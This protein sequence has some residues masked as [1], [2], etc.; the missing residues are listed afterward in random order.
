MGTTYMNFSTGVF[1][2]DDDAPLTQEQV[3]SVWHHL[4][5]T[6][7]GWVE[8][9][10]LFVQQRDDGFAFD[11]GPVEPGVKGVS[12]DVRLGKAKKSARAHS[13]RKK[14]PARAHATKKSPAQLDR[15]IAEVVPGWAR[16]LDLT[17]S[18]EL[19]KRLHVSQAELEAKQR[20]IESDRRAALPSLS[21]T[22][23]GGGIFV[24]VSSPGVGYGNVAAVEKALKAFQIPI[25]N[26]IPPNIFVP[27]HKIA[28]KT[29]A[30][31]KVEE[32]LRYAGYRV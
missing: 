30:R 5:T 16:G 4:P 12:P 19:A 25:G 29:K 26:A 11:L 27:V 14:K 32:A 18:R 28:D 9:G 8:K 23:T 13:T 31:E 7:A 10:H 17:E 24:R 1:H 3:D 22:D 2:V 15:E 20:R 21:I 6:G